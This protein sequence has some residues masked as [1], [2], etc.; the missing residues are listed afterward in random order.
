MH[1]IKFGSL[2]EC[3][4]SQFNYL[5]IFALRIH[6]LKLQFAKQNL[7]AI[8]KKIRPVK[9]L[10]TLIDTIFQEQKANPFFTYFLAKTK[11]FVFVSR[12]LIS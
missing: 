4:T 5:N 10:I 9:F 1:L 8:Q 7:S 6:C 3:P 12:C 2:I 11:V